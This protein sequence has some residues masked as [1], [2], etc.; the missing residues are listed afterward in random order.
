MVKYGMIYITCIQ[1]GE[2]MK[3]YKIA[4]VLGMS[5]LLLCAC[6]DGKETQTTESAAATEEETE[7]ATAELGNID[8]LYSDSFAEPGEYKGIEIEYVVPVPSDAEIDSKIDQD[9]ES[10]TSTE[11]VG[12]RPV[13]D[14]DIV[15]IDYVGTL[16]G[17]A[18]DGGT[19][20]G[21]DL[22]IGSG[23][24][25]DG[26]ES[27]L[28]GAKK[29][30]VVELNL[31][32][33]ENYKAD[34][35]GKAVVFKVTVNEISEKIKPELNDET[36]SK[37]GAGYKSVDEYKES[38]R[39]ALYEANKATA[40]SYARNSIVDKLRETSKI[41]STPDWLL[42]SMTDNVRNNAASYAAMYG[43]SIEDF[44]S[45]A[46]GETME[47]F[48][49]EC[50][51]YGKANAE[52]MVIAFA[53]AQKENLKVSDEELKSKLDEYMQSY[54]MSEDELEKSGQKDYMTL[55]IQNEKVIDYIYDNAVF[56]D[57]K[58]NKVTP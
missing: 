29:G 26:F 27:G 15:N 1:R 5:A 53:I 7:G 35:A 8:E 23:Q 9:L 56:V 21:Y 58:G 4:I 37:I 32:F 12:D 16:D 54:E 50:K 18:F 44:V 17:V 19:A 51:D 41:K 28:I 6:G 40:V 10:L 3:K 48:E 30:D 43:L 36:V 42:N 39:E 57:E 2:K 46:L 13:Q 25:I 31:T 14:G 22:T 38:V 49:A 45:Q 34:L 52:G 47:E 24:F 11:S 33:P 55:Y 20:S